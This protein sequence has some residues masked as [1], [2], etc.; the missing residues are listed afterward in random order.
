MS[1]NTVINPDREIQLERSVSSD[2]H[3]PSHP[4]L[5][6]IALKLKIDAEYVLWCV[7]R[8]KVTTDGLSGHFTKEAA[9][10]IALESGLGWT[11]RNFNR[12]I[13]A[14]RD[15]FWGTDTERLYIRS[16]KR[17]Y[18]LLADDNAAAI[19]SSMFVRIKAHRSAL[20]RRA[21]LYWSWFMARSEQS[22]SRGILTEL[23]GLSADQ[24][25]DYERELGSRLLIKSNFCHIDADLY[26]TR[27]KYI[28]TYAYAFIQEKFHNDTIELINVIAYQMPNTYI[29]RESKH[30]VSPLTFAPKR[31]LSVSRTLYR[32]TLPCSYNER[33]YYDFYDQWEQDMNP[34]AYIRTFYQGSK[35]IHRQG[36]YF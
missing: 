29:A 31:A 14:G 35:R 16:F 3:F 17:V 28:P 25:R 6:R 12:I 22:I 21:E 19:P 24:Q 8:H 26:S 4:E 1:I 9:Y 13:A 33:C 7:L 5:N 11:R 30:G 18:K 15:T 2:S 20:K 36:Q 23:F 27:L 10:T 32:D 34:H